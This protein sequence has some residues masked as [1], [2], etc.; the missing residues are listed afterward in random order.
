LT[1]CVHVQFPTLQHDSDA[2]IRNEA[3]AGSRKNRRSE[4]RGAPIIADIEDQRFS[5]SPT[6]LQTTGARHGWQT[7]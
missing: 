6:M 2:G 4:Q 5:A 1:G 7:K 3:G